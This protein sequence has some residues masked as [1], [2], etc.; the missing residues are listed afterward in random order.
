MQVNRD[1]LLGAIKGSTTHAET[2]G[3]SDEPL[4][5]C[6][7]CGRPVR[8][9]HSYVMVVP[10][11]RGRMFFHAGCEPPTKSESDLAVERMQAARQERLQ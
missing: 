3:V 11:G 6:K 5:D 10:V 9:D 1:R 7:R 2:Q 4:S 8:K